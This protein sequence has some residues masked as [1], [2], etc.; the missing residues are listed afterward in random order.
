MVTIDLKIK[1]IL[2][3]VNEISAPAERQFVRLDLK[4][5]KQQ[6]KANVIF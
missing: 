5:Q 4:Q 6:Q 3:N 2:S 1:V